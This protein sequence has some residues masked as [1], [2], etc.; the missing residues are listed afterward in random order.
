[1]FPA[2]PHGPFGLGAFKFLE[3]KAHDRTFKHPMEKRKKAETRVNLS[4]RWE[5]ITATKEMNVSL[6]DNEGGE[7]GGECTAFR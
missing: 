1:M 6:F 2:G 4:T 5:R 3:Y 7:G